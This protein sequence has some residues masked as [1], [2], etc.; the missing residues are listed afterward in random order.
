MSMS[1]SICQTCFDVRVRR[2]PEEKRR[3][4]ELA[5]IGV[6]IKQLVRWASTYKRAAGAVE[7]WAVLTDIERRLVEFVLSVSSADDLENG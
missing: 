1:A 5:R 3:L 6:H 7:V 4:G 2:T